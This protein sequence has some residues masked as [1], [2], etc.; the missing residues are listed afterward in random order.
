MQYGGKVSYDLSVSL[1]ITLCL[2][3]NHILIV[4][5]YISITIT[6]T[7]EY[8]FILLIFHIKIWHNFKIQ[9]MVV[10]LFMTYVCAFII[11]MICNENH[12]LIVTHYIN[13]TITF[14]I[15]YAFILV[16][17]HINKKDDTIEYIM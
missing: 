13:I 14:M 4:T 3:E 7:I 9:S 12:I 16:I 6:C 2:S 5:L 8:T 11:S 15:T 10:T 17:F 1:N